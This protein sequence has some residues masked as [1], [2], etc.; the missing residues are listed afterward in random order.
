MWIDPSDTKYMLNG[1][2][3][4]VYETFDGGENWR[5]AQ[6]LPVTQFYDVAVDNASPFYFVYGGTQDNNSVG[7]PSRTRSVSGITNADWFITQGG[8]GFRS[9]ADPEDPN[10]VYAESQYG[11]LARYDRR[12]GN[13]TGIQPPESQKGVPLRWNWDSP[14]IVSPHQ[15]ARIYFAAQMLFESD[16]RGDSWKPVSGDLTRHLDRDKLPVMGKIWGPDA[17]AKNR[18]TSFYGNIVALQESPKQAGLLFVGTD[19]GLIQ[20]TDNGGQSW[21]KDHSFRAFLR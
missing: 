20:I 18:S 5:Y 10:T 14:L 17:V 6:N 11:V 9:M 8:D 4:G 1:C 13:R 7:G 2:D 3:G 12:T 15:H 21:R 16:D 19:D